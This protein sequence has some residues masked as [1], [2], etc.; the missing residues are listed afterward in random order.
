M[1]RFV[2]DLFY[3]IIFLGFPCLC[4]LGVAYHRRNDESRFIE[5]STRIISLMGF[6]LWWLCTYMMY[7]MG[8]TDLG[9]EIVV[10][11]IYERIVFIILPILI[12]AIT[13]L[14]TYIVKRNTMVDSN[15][16]YALLIIFILVVDWQ[17]LAIGQTSSGLLTSIQQQDNTVIY[18]LTWINL[19]PFVIVNLITFLAI[20]VALIRKVP[21]R[22]SASH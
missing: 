3:L 14:Y 11:Q 16:N 21:W 19:L 9:F 8:N 12:L 17:F 18:K 6:L 1:L 10:P 15:R 5:I 20:T 7:M 13:F 22:K 4:C 2:V